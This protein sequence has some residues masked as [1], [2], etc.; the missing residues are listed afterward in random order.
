MLMVV[1]AVWGNYNYAYMAADDDTAASLAGIFPQMLNTFIDATTAPVQG[2][3][4]PGSKQRS[5][6]LR[7]GGAIVLGMVEASAA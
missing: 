4:G 1:R 6:I 3:Y 5:Q 2:G 7:L